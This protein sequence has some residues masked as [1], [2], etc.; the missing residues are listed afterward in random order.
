MYETSLR[1]VG[2]STMLTVPPAV[3]NTM[4]LGPGSRVGLAVDNGRLIV[5]PVTR[6]RYSLEEL[7]A[8]C[9]PSAAPPAE[10][11]AWLQAKPVGNEL[12]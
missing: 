5:E 10:D 1:K 12:I 9:D 4:V 8:Q 2:G 3:L 11:Q 6:P 7:I